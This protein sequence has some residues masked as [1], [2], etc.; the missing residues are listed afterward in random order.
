M[1]YTIGVTIIDKKTKEEYS[2]YY[3][4]GEFGFMYVMTKDNIPSLLEKKS[5]QNYSLYI[6]DNVKDAEYFCRS[7]SRS[8]RRDDVWANQSLKSRKI[9][10][11]YPLK[12]DSS[13]FIFELDE[14]YTHSKLKSDCY[15]NGIKTGTGIDLPRTK[16]L[17]LK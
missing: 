10:R 13:N 17:K 12:V 7:L 14:N 3:A 8:Y 6:F 11:F 16:I 9:R 5:L 2:G 1:R 4:C 15:G